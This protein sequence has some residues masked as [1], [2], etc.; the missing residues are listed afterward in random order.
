MAFYPAQRDGCYIADWLCDLN[1]QTGTTQ[2]QKK[3]IETITG[4][5]YL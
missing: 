1:C 3:R 5:V 4:E 2:A